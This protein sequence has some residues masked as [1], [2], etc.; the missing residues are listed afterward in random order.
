[1]EYSAILGAETGGKTNQWSLKDGKKC[2][3]ERLIF[4]MHLGDPQ[5]AKVQN[6][7]FSKFFY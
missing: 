6:L 3:R 1:M 5:L 4:M 7:Y 2:L